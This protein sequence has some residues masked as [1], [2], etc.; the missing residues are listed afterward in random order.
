M[1]MVENTQCY[2]AECKFFQNKYF[3]TQRDWST[4]WGK[5]V[6]YNAHKTLKYI[7]KT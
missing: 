5:L 6:L 3:E 4:N 2:I 1:L 7:N